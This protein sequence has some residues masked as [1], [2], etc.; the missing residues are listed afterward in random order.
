M[1]VTVDELHERGIS[2]TVRRTPAHRGIEGNEQADG[3]AKR[4]AEG[5]GDR[6]RP[7]FQ[8]EATSRERPRGPGPRLPVLGPAATSRGSI[9][10]ALP[11]GGRLR[12]GL[13]RMRKELAGRFYQ[14]LSGHAATA[15]HVVRI[16]QAPSNKCWSCGSGER[17]SRYHLL[18][19]CQ[20]WTPEI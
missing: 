11:P 12:K 7:E 17:Q 2:V 5:G 9:A 1:I 8:M 14:L 15:E 18:V 20:R 3:A 16:G 13:G 10:T 6:A 19:R 4:A